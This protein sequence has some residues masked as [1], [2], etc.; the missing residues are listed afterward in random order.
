M[1]LNHHNDHSDQQD[2]I[3]NALAIKKKLECFD[4]VF[5]LAMMSKNLETTHGISQLLQSLQC[6]LSKA[7]DLIKSS[8]EKL[9]NMRN[10]YDSF[11]DTAV[12]LAKAWGIKDHFEDRRLK[13]ANRLLDEMCHDESP[14]STEKRFKVNVFLATVDRACGQ[15]AQRFHSL[16]SLAATFSVLLPSTFSVLLPSTFSVL[17]P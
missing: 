17:L 11:H 1:S 4:F 2:E 8:H 15:I 10:E 12:S 9:Q 14:A 16:S 3:A 7:N 5:I 13:K 6:D